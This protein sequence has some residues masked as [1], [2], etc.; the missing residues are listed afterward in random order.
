[1]RAEWELDHGGQADA[2]LAE[3][4][5]HLARACELAP[6]RA[7]M[8]NNLGNAH[9]A[10]ARLALARGVDPAGA[11]TAAADAYR[12]AM[13]AA[14]AA[15]ASPRFNLAAVHLT[16]AQW[17]LLV[18]Q[19]PRAVLDEAAA[20][21][22]AALAIDKDDPYAP[23]LLARVELLRARAALAA[24]ESPETH[25]TAGARRLAG[26]APG[27]P[28]A[29]VARGELHL[30]AARWRAG[31][32]AEVDELAAAADAAFAEAGAA[33]GVAGLRGRAEAALLRAGVRRATSLPA[34]AELV[35]GLELAAKALALHPTDA[36]T[37]A[38][39]GR[40]LAV[41]ARAAAGPTRAAVAKEA[42]AALRAAVAECPPLERWVADELAEMTAMAR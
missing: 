24:G 36:E 31:R 37:L 35:S 11:A 5:A 14:E 21:T 38:V 19:D 9:R 28:G 2:S 8:W 15:H 41:R 39:R 40:L 6:G 7:Y 20:E 1:M 18:G 26:A 34:E 33:G 17:R 12:R 13:A 3:A 23:A 30:V 4:T 42:E 16:R 32:V 29:A 10:R 22:Q 25:L 27:A